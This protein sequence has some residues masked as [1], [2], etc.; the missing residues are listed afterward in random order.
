M[1]KIT[2]FLTFESGGKD[3][4]DFYVSIFKNSKIN[5]SMVMPGTNQ[6]FHANFTLDGQNFMAMDAGPDFKFEQGFSLYVNCEDQA[7]VDYFWD[8]LGAGGE[9]QQC[10]WLK[11]KYGISW[12]IIPKQL[13]E[14]MQ[15]PDKEKAGRVMQ[16][17]L[18][19][20][21]ID[22]KGLQDAAENK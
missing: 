15:D 5:S 9:I 14:L 3:A 4:V 12:Q 18:K 10:G 11:D 17:M 13:G 1:Q 7:E 21:K 8:K 2:T 20:V 19:M 16:A 22:I 6:L